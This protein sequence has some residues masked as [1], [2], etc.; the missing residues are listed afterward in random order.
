MS[1][2]VKAACA[3]VASHPGPLSTVGECDDM[4]L[5]QAQ[6]AL[7]GRPV[8]PLPPLAER[9]DVAVRQIR[10]AAEDKGEHIAM[11]EAR[12]QY[13]CGSPRAFPTPTGRL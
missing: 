13:G 10:L 2:A 12:K 3:A 8:L 9:C 4:D 7:E 5:Q 6:A 1:E 11:L